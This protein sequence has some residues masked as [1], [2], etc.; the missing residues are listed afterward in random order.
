MYT[1]SPPDS[2]SA[3]E[4]ETA[5]AERDP[6]WA[7]G[8][9]LRFVRDLPAAVGDV[10]SSWTT[11]SGVA[12]WW[13]P[14]HFT[15]AEAE[16][17]PVPGGRLRIALQEG[18]GARYDSAGRFVMVHSPERLQFELAPLLPDGGPLFSALYLVT[19]ADR[20]KRTRL[21]LEIRITDTL[22]EAAA[23]IA[24]IELG[25]GQALDKLSRALS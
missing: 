10:W 25:W 16:V 8:R 18:G 12:E 6:R 19:L 20:A 15:V 3:V 14:D 21:G 5:L 11:A 2:S 24:G 23:A 22:P 4:R 1:R 17:D 9:T 13:A 7:V